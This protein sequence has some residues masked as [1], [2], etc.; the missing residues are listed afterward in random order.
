[1]GGGGVD[2]GLGGGVGGRYKKE[3]G[4][5]PP[6]QTEAQ[7]AR[8]SQTHDA[9][10][11]SRAKLPPP[12]RDGGGGGGGAAL[13]GSCFPLPKIICF[14]RP[15][16]AIVCWSRTSS[17][18]SSSSSLEDNNDDG[19]EGGWRCFLVWTMIIG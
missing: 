3:K 10:W 13:A 9:K 12:P 7:R 4:G 19:K 16:L 8:G 17:S 1:M 2:I 11:Y 6:P 15:C 5:T 14:P 18:S